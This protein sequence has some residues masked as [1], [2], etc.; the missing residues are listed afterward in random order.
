VYH[1]H[2]G[3]LLLAGISHV[4]RV[5][6]IADMEFRIKA[7]MTRLNVGRNEAIARIREI[8]KQRIKWTQFL[9]GV[10]WRDPSLYDIVLNLEHMSVDSACEIV[11]RMTE[12]E[13]FKPTPQ[14]MKAM[15]DLT[16][17]SLVWAALSR[18]PRTRAADVK[19]VADDGVVTI[20]GTTRSESVLL[21][22]PLVARQ[23]EGVKDVR[24]EV[25][26]GSVYV[27]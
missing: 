9:Y 27:K 5:R 7:A 12:L 22:I 8:D 24:S 4:I 15:E 3:H 1:G 14:S 18:D 13:D 23:V 17:G 26:I 21:A 19:V 20:T 10:E 16:L 2:A 6:V 25:G 11:A